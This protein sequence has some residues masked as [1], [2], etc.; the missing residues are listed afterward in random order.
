MIRQ[1][2]SVDR[3]RRVYVLS[4]AHEVSLE[5]ERSE[6]STDEDT[7]L[8]CQG[9]HQLEFPHNVETYLNTKTFDEHTVPKGLLAAHSTNE[10]T[11]GKIVIECGQLNYVVDDL[12]NDTRV[13][14]PGVDGIIAPQMLHHL[15]ITEPVKFHIEFHRKSK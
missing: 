7:S 5:T 3:E 14:K 8:F 13:L 15:E 10:H 6:S 12:D 9:C 2:E 4:C 1:I 11:W